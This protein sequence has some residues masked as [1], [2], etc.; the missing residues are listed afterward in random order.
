MTAPHWILI[1]F[2]LPP[3]ALR[4]WSVK[5]SSASEYFLWKMD[6]RP[7]NDSFI[8]YRSTLLCTLERSE[9]TLR[10][11]VK[12]SVKM[13]AELYVRE[14]MYANPVYLWRVSLASVNV[15]TQTDVTV[16]NVPG[17]HPI[18]ANRMPCRVLFRR[19]RRTPCVAVL[20]QNK[21]KTTFL[22]YL[23]IRETWITVLLLLVYLHLS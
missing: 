2:L 4:H 18:W 7:W 8:V 10:V 15:I 20:F 3:R 11:L 12:R 1:E 9:K 22:R 16:I 21:I 14:S 6:W 23:V 19:A 17:N 13:Q 5:A